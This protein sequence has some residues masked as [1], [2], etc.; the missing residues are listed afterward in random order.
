MV[1]RRQRS[2]GKRFAAKAEGVDVQSGPFGRSW[3]RVPVTAPLARI[4]ARNGRSG[5]RDSDAGFAA[6][7]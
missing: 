4:A 7:R 2:D 5:V 1:S 3:S 6:V